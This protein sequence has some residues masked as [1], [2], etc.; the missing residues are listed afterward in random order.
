[1]NHSGRAYDVIDISQT[2]GEVGGDALLQLP[3]E[4]VERDPKRTGGE[5]LP[6]EIFARQDRPS[7]SILRAAKDSVRPGVHGVGNSPIGSC[8]VMAGC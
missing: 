5:T 3:V 6:I 1:M 7:A 4:A 8:V 2:R